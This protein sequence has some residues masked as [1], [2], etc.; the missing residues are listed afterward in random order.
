MPPAQPRRV[1]LRAGETLSELRRELEL[2]QVQLAERMAV[3]QRAISHLE[4][5]PNPRVATLASYVHGLG[6]RLELRAV[7]ADRTVDLNLHEPQ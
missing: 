3:S 4:H 7:L 1:D 5:E 6:G 2:T